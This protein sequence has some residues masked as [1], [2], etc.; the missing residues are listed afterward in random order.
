MSVKILVTF[1]TPAEILQFERAFHAMTERALQIFAE[2]I[3][4]RPYCRHTCAT[5]EL[6]KGMAELLVDSTRAI[7]KLPDDEELTKK[8]AEIIHAHFPSQRKSGTSMGEVAYAVS[9][10]PR[11]TLNLKIVTTLIFRR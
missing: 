1:E 4:A 9:K 3:G 6:E 7:A 10:N 11:T 8:L 5:D 2:E